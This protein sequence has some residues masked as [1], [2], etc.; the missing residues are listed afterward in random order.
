MAE[1]DR[2]DAAVRDGEVGGEAGRAAPVEHKTVADEDVV[3]EGPTDQR[4]RC[5]IR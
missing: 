1:V 4:E 2:R 3:H 5:V